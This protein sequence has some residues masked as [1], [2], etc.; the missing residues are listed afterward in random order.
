MTKNI[1]D[2]K[3]EEF[4]FKIEKE[5]SLS[6]EEAVNSLIRKTFISNI[7]FIYYDIPVDFS[8]TF[9]LFGGLWIVTNV[10]YKFK[11]FYNF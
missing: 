10:F 9:L 1:R 8:L 2:D 4:I 3:E 5:L 7:G 11:H 6:W